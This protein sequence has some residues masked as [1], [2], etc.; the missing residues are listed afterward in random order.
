MLDFNSAMQFGKLKGQ[1]IKDTLETHADYYVWLRNERIKNE[2]SNLFTEEVDAKLR[3]YVKG[4]HH[5]AERVDAN[6]DQVTAKLKTELET[7]KTRDELYSDQW[8]AF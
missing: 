2:R 5:M 7:I 8:G 4:R 3:G 1:K 6:G